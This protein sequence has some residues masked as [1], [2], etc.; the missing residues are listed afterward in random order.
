[1]IYTF[2]SKEMEK[3]VKLPEFTY[4][5]ALLLFCLYFEFNFLEYKSINKKYLNNRISIYSGIFR[6]MNSHNVNLFELPEYRNEK[7]IEL[8][9]QSIRK[10]HLSLEGMPE[11]GING[12][13]VQ[14]RNLLL[15]SLQGKIDLLKEKNRI[16]EKLIL[17]KYINN[18]LLTINVDE[19]SLDD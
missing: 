10:F 12:A 5:E 17:E 16:F 8:Q 11:H 15:D 7:G 19:I 4:D 6:V 18:E 9:L 3:N 2:I 14:F 1:M 13:S